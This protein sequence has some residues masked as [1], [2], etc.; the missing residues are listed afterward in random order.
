MTGRNDYEFDTGVLERPG[1]GY[2][3]PPVPDPSPMPTLP[4]P[5]RRYRDPPIPNTQ[6]DRSGYYNLPGNGG[7]ITPP[8]RMPQ[9]WTPEFLQNYFA[10][11]GATPAPTSIDYWMGKQ[12]ELNQRGQQIGDPDYAMKRLAAA[13][14]IIGGPQNSPF[15]E[16]GGGMGG[17]MNLGWLL[18]LLGSRLPQQAPMPQA[19]SQP[20]PQG[21][22]PVDLQ[23][24]I[25]AA[26]QRSF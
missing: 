21:Q 17:G 7:G 25:Q 24:I 2:Q 10:S 19:M 4:N 26:L 23:S 22:M 8:S 16:S 9:S 15:R 1:R 11:R 13:D 3:D 5:T 6:R 20:M 14:E 12:Q 18:Q